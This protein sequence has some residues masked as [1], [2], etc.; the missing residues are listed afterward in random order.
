M[1][2]IV[3]YDFTILAANHIWFYLLPLLL[4]LKQITNE[5]LKLWATLVTWSLSHDND[6]HVQYL[7][8]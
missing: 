5:Y 7:F 4:Y 8:N 1:Y 2:V 3:S 6:Y